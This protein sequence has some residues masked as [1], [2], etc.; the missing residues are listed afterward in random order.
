MEVYIRLYHFISSG[1]WRFIF[2]FTNYVTSG[3]WWL[4]L[5]FT[6]NMTSGE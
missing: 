3:E 5:V 1:K 2:I 4:L 6:N